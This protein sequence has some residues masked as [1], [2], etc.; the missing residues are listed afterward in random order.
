MTNP[1]NFGFT[2]SP[3]PQTGVFSVVILVPNNEDPSPSSLHFT[4]NV[5]Q[6]GATNTSTFSASS[7]LFS[8]TPWTVGQLDAFLMLSGGSN[9][10]NPI[11]AWLPWVQ[12]HG[13]AGATGFFLYVVNLGTD[14]VA[15]NASPGTGPLL[16]A[17][18]PFPL[19]TVAVGF[20]DVGTTAPDFI[21]T[22]NSGA[23]FEGGVPTPEPG[24]LLLFGS[25]LLGVAGI[26]RKRLPH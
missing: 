2:V 10:S 7:T 21:G 19:A 13:D 25:G 20:L 26:V 16:T 4:L 15:D 6:G 11:G 22:A 5:T 18:G 1:P 8:S 24:T 12:A 17:T 23:L 9:P 14:K 3:G